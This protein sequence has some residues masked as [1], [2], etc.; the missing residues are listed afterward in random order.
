MAKKVKN[1]KYWEEFGKR[2]G[3]KFGESKVSS[4][5]VCF[6]GGS[7]FA[8]LILLIGLYWL[9]K[10]MGWIQPQVSIWAVI[11]IIVGAYWFLKSMFR[12]C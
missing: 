6:T 1:A 2:M 5:S 8:L 7:S 4:H 3:R 10:D 12:R 11:F 9:A